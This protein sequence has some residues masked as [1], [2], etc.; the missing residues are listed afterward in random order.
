[1]RSQGKVY[2]ERE[3]KEKKKGILHQKGQ[4]KKKV[5]WVKAVP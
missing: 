4:E 5:C 3:Q 2:K 1:M